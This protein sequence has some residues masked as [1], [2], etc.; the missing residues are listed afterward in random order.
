MRT[1]VLP[2]LFLAFAIQASSQTNIFVTPPQYPAAT[3]PVG[4][5]VG[6]FRGDG[7]L[8]LAVTNSGC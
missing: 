5:A 8:D 7:K 1:R 2:I 4:I 3:G 6:D